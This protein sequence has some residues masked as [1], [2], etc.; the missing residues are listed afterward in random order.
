MCRFDLTSV[1]ILVIFSLVV[2]AEVREGS[3]CLLLLQCKNT[4][5]L[6]ASRGKYELGRTKTQSEPSL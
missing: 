3:K 1:G 5:R 2:D 6:I 4:F